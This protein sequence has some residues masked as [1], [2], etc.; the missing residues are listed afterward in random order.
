MSGPSKSEQNRPVDQP[1]HLNLK[2][3]AQVIN[4]FFLSFLGAKSLRLR[5]F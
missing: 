2:V 5:L 3:K 1:P 4:S